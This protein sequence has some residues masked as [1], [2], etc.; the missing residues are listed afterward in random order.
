MLVSCQIPWDDDER[1]LEDL[2]REEIRMTLGRGFRDLYIFGTAG[3][4]YAVDRSRFE[5]IVTIFREETDDAEIFPQVGVIGLSTA[6]VQERIEFAYRLG[7]RMFQI[8]LPCW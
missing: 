1:L 4:G 8:S 7:F 2:F 5:R 6:C 3:E